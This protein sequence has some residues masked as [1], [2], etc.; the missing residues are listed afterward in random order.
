MI[1]GTFFPLR[2]V[3]SH[4]TPCHKFYRNRLYPLRIP[5]TTSVAYRFAYE[6][7]SLIPH[8]LKHLFIFKVQRIFTLLVDIACDSAKISFCVAFLWFKMGQQTVQEE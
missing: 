8:E 2:M 5:A 6:L 4:E 7:S 1:F 3:S